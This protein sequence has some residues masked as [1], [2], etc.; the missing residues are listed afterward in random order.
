MLFFDFV[1][2][3]KNDMRAIV[4]AF[5][6]KLLKRSRHCHRPMC[7]SRMRFESKKI[8]NKYAWRCTIS[9]CRKLLFLR[10]N[11]IFENSKLFIQVI[12]TL[13]FFS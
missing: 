2:Q 5:R 9:R 4:F 7:R 3:T 13:L 11:S 8:I 10:K 1:N 6:K 12:V